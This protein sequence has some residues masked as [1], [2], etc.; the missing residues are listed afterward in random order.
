MFNEQQIKQ[1][2]ANK[3]VDKCSPKSITY[4]SSFKLAAVKK[5]YERGE[6]PSMI[7]ADAGFDL[8]LIDADRA[9]DALRRWRAIYND[10]GQ[11][12]L[13]K[14]SRGGHGKGGKTKTKYDNDKDK[15][16]YLETKLA[17]LEEENKMLKKMEKLNKA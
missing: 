17:Y 4:N 5:Y 9:K 8:N 7:F 14:S 6:S 13:L 2:L 15:I 12:E 10:Q 1:I 11:Q 16:E 3:N